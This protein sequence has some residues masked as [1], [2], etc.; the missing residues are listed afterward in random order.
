MCIFFLCPTEFQNKDHTPVN[1]D[2]GD[3]K[4]ASPCLQLGIEV[5]GIFL[6][7]E[8]WLVHV[9]LNHGGT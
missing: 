6:Y 5:H 9:S 2:G 3:K 4:V 8:C 1:A 7:Q